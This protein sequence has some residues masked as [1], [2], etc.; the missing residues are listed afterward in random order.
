LY[1]NDVPTHGTHIDIALTNLVTV[2]SSQHRRCNKC[3]L[4]LR[5]DLYKPPVSV[6][7]KDHKFAM[8]VRYQE[9]GAR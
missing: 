6:P 7:F 5:K 2:H 4:T 3:V 1:Q 9:E 8:R